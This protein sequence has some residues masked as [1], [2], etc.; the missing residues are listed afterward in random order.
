MPTDF[1][2]VDWTVYI[3]DATYYIKQQAN[4]D[5]ETYTLIV[6]HYNDGLYTQLTEEDSK[7]VTMLYIN[8]AAVS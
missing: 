4:H 5:S 8:A 3:G 1:K 7:K 6:Y 2:D